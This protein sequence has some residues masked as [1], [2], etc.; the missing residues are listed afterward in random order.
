MWSARRY[1]ALYV[2]DLILI[3]HCL[4]SSDAKEHIGDNL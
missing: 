3:S 2:V 1:F 4:V